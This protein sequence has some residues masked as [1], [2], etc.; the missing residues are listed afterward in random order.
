MRLHGKGGLGDQDA[1]V[2]QLLTLVELEWKREAAY[3]CYRRKAMQAAKK[4]NATLKDKGIKEGDLVLRYDN[5]LDNRFDAKF[6][7]R[8]QGPYIVKKVFNSSY[9]QLMDLDGKE[10]SKRVNGYRLKPYLSR[11]LPTDLQK[12]PQKGDKRACKLG[13]L[14]DGCG[15]KHKEQKKDGQENHITPL[16]L[17]GL[18]YDGT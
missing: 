13:G 14:S 5:R 12:Q 4:F 10:H 6:E 16:A 9:Y 2:D 17:E 8:W 3:E 7:T 15:A 1:W 11:I 18:H